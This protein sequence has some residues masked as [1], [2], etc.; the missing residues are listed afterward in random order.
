MSALS[1]VPSAKSAG[2]T[3]RNGTDEWVASEWS[4]IESRGCLTQDAGELP[5]FIPHLSPRER[6]VCALLVKGWPDK[7]IA[8]ALNISVSVVRF[9]LYHARLKRKCSNRTRLAVVISPEF[10]G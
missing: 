9:H 4:D 10:P 3:K 5:E 6:E 7:E 1:R 2:F 8:A